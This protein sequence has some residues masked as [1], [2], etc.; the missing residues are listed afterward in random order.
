MEEEKKIY[1]S[2]GGRIIPITIEE[3]RTL[4]KLYAD[5]ARWSVLKRGPEDFKLYTERLL[6]KYTAEEIRIK[7]RYFTIFS[8]V[9]GE[10]TNRV[11]SGRGKRLLK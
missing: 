5:T 3:C 6:E 4:D 2:I 8:G 9:S 11:T 1:V 10:K 7:K